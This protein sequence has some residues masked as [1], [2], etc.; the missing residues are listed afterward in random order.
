VGAPGTAVDGETMAKR[1]VRAV[2]AAAAI[3]SDW[4]PEFSGVHI[5]RHLTY[6]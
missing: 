6:D 2:V 5:S 3:D 1:A 4:T